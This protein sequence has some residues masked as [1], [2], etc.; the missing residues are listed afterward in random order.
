MLLS[1]LFTSFPACQITFSMSLLKQMPVPPFVF[2]PHLLRLS[3]FLPPVDGL[4]WYLP[5]SL[6]R[7]QWVFS[8]SS[9]FQEY[10]CHHLHWTLFHAWELTLHT[11]REV[12]YLGN[13]I[14]HGQGKALSL[15][16]TISPCS[17]KEE[18]RHCLCEDVSADIINWLCTGECKISDS[19]GIVNW[20][21]I[22]FLKKLGWDI[23]NSHRPLKEVGLYQTLEYLNIGSCS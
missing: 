8:V 3:F 7:K 19:H 14:T 16:T 21:F 20:K 22:S 4:L 11:Q 12:C 15:N 17:E 9:V 6:C 1:L 23:N 18:R 10:F 5:P 13:H 2:S